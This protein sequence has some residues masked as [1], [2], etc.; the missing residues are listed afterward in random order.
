MFFYYLCKVQVIHE[1]DLRSWKILVPKTACKGTFNLVLNLVYN[2][3][4]YGRSNQ[5]SAC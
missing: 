4:F 2:T 5:D 1:T 3:T